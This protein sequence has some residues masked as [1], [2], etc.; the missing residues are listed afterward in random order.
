MHAISNLCIWRIPIDHLTHQQTM[1][2]IFF[3]IS[4]LIWSLLLR[5]LLLLND[6]AESCTADQT[7]LGDNTTDYNVNECKDLTLSTQQ[8][9]IPFVQHTNALSHARIPRVNNEYRYYSLGF[10]FILTF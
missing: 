7:N 2:M 10:E 3:S 1:I 5:L 9:L 4:L 6:V 8:S